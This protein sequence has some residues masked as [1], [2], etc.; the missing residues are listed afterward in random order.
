LGRDCHEAF[1]RPFCGN[2]CSFCG[3]APDAWTNLNYPLNI[4]TKAGEPKQIQMAVVG[5]TDVQG[6]LEGVL[7]TLRD[8]TSLTGLKFWTED[9][10]GFAGLVGRDPR[11]VEIYRQIQKV[12]E[13]DYPVLIT[14][15]TGT[16]KE[17]RANSS[18]TS[19]VPFPGRCG[20]KKAGLS[21]PT[22]GRY[23]WMK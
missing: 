13:H 14:G 12:A 5:M 15:E 11:M 2:Q 3:Q 16:G 19:K 4:V 21:W 23:F 18:D 9:A 1:G 7:A 17:L 10:T 6:H 8:I 22:E 20:I